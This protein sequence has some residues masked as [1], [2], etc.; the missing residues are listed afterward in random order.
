MACYD[1]LKFIPIET[2]DGSPIE[3]LLSYDDINSD[4][5]YIYDK[6]ICGFSDFESISYDYPSEQ[7]SYDNNLKVNTS[8]YF[9][10]V[11]TLKIVFKSDENVNSKGF[12]LQ[13]DYLENFCVC[14]NGVPKI[15]DCKENGRE[16]CLSCSGNYG[17]KTYVDEHS[18]WFNSSKPN[19][20]EKQRCYQYKCVCH[21]GEPVKDQ[22]CTDELDNQCQSCN[23]GYHLNTVT[24]N[25]DQNVCI[26]PNGAK[27]Y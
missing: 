17:L 16:D 11:K 13:V 6:E 26:C 14:P 4:H 2:L 5:N 18:K 24:K 8:L 15:N 25:C 12:K 20:A 27:N 1:Y 7:D 22:G 10:N 21:N 19:W 9:N 3:D 23:V